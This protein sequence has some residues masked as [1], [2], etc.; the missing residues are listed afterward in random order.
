MFEIKLVHTSRL[1][2]GGKKTAFLWQ[3]IK[4]ITLGIPVLS[5]SGEGGF[6]IHNVTNNFIE[7]GNSFLLSLNIGA[8][9]TCATHVINE[10]KHE[11]QIDRREEDESLWFEYQVIIRVFSSVCLPAWLL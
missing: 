1:T 11:K 4:R 9:C 10:A 8:Q 6:I 2:P 5:P 7:D 3:E